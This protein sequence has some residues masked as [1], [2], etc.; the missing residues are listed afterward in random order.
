MPAKPDPPV[1]SDDEQ[2][3]DVEVGEAALEMIRL[4]LFERARAAVGHPH[5]IWPSTVAVLTTSLLPHNAACHC[6]SL[7]CAVH[8]GLCR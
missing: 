6:S 3:E 7:H 5:S 4:A 2:D 1:E 8:A